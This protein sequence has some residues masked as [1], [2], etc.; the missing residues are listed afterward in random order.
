MRRFRQS[1]K[2]R[3]FLKQRRSWGITFLAVG[4]LSLVL[5]FSRSAQAQKAQLA[6]QSASVQP[7]SQ[8]FN[9]DLTVKAGQVYEQDV[10]VY[11]GNVTVESG[12][13][14][15]GNLYVYSGDVEVEEGGEVRG[16]IAAFS[17]DLTIA[18]KIGGGISA[19]SGDIELADGATVGGDVSVLSGEITQDSG[20]R[21]HGNVVRGPNFK[22]PL[23]QLFQSP[24][25]PSSP[26]AVQMMRPQPASIWGGIFGF[27]L[28]LIGA[29]VLTIL[30]TL[31]AWLLY[32]AR[33]DFVRKVRNTIEEQPALSF[34]VGAIVNLG[35]LF[36]T[37]I[38]F[39]TICL[40]PFGLATGL[41]L[42]LLNI[43]GWAA[44]SLWVGERLSRYAKSSA[45]PVAYLVL[46]VIV[47]SG[48]IGL[49]WALGCWRTCIVLAALLASSP[50]VGALIVPWL[51]RGRLAGRGINNLG[52]PVA[53]T[54][55]SAAPVEGYPATPT[56]PFSPP[57]QTETEAPVT[58]SVGESP[59][60]SGAALETP[61]NPVA[62][63]DFTRIQ[64]LSPAFD[65]RLKAVGILTYAQLLAMTPEVVA[66]ILGIPVQ[67]VLSDDILGQARM[68]AAQ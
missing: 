7:Q 39:V 3:K 60:N 33:P 64:G 40:I 12:G 27:I 24:P 50:G 59:I 48:T 49:L 65:Q 44:M 55:P 19:W 14:I 10:S 30:I 47:T 43:A 6:N 58:P 4:L 46:G 56:E 9:D 23:P 21:I 51:N 62:E 29:G 20:A 52:A 26:D 45:Q 25:T 31:L 53:P 2:S 22:I 28:R 16:D 11:D 54:E 13:T 38:F 41:I 17:G 36:V 8:I 1:S 63:V 68:L 57:L 18:G 15:Q 61:I 66:A 42:L 35:L 34:A 32:T 5:I 37:F 67:Q